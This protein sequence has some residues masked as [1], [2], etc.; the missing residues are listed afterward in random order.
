LEAFG[1]GGNVSRGY[2]R[3]EVVLEDENGNTIYPSK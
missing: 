3:V 2:G 1:L